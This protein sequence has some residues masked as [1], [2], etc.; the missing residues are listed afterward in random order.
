MMETALTGGNSMICDWTHA[1]R[2]GI[3]G[4]ES[5]HLGDETPDKA[6]RTVEENFM[7]IHETEIQKS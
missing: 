4:H 2:S 1:F 5:M 3:I 7:D 6:V